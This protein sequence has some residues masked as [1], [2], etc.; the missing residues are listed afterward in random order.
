LAKLQ[1]LQPDEVPYEKIKTALTESL[2]KPMAE[3]FDGVQKKPCQ[4]GL[5]VQSHKMILL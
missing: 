1:N 2:G 5:L 4:L 3:L